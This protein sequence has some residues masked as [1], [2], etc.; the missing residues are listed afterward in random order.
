MTRRS[1]VTIRPFPPVHTRRPQVARPEIRGAKVLYKV[2]HLLRRSGRSSCMARCLRIDPMESTAKQSL[3]PGAKTRMGAR[4]RQWLGRTPVASVMSGFPTSG[5]EPAR[6][7]IRRG[8][9]PVLFEAMKVGGAHP[10]LLR[11]SRTDG[12]KVSAPRLP[13]T[14]CRRSKPVSVICPSGPDRPHPGYKGREPRHFFRFADSAPVTNGAAGR[15]AAG[16]KPEDSG[17]CS[18][19]L[20]LGR[21]GNSWRERPCSCGRCPCRQRRPPALHLGKQFGGLGLVAGGDGFSTFF[22]AVTRCL[23]TSELTALSLTSW[24][25]RLQPTPG[26]GYC[27]FGFGNHDGVSAGCRMM[28]AKPVVN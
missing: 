20:D 22:T 15:P 11:E 2:E 10:A 4:F 23:G 26:A 27:S 19:G 9:Y 16:L 18:Q 25:A 14:T 12:R 28:S 3:H 5:R 13:T 24:R 7:A 1:R 8:A 6:W 21:G 17:G